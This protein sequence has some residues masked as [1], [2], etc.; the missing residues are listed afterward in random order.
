SEARRAVAMIHLGALAVL[1]TP[2]SE[3]GDLFHQAG[4]AECRRGKNDVGEGVERRRIGGDVR[5]RGGVRAANDNRYGERARERG[6]KTSARS[7]RHASRWRASPRRARS[8]HHF[9]QCPRRDQRMSV[10]KET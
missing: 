7:D 9:T 10:M 3:R 4:F 8:S 6:K 2:F 1:G 5:D